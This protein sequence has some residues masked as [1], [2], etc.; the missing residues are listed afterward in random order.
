[1][2]ALGVC[3]EAEGRGEEGKGCPLLPYTIPKPSKVAKELPQP[4]ER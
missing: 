4:Q 3:G 2:P 1:M